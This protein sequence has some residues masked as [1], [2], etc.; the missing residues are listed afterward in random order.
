MFKLLWPQYS[1]LK[2]SV[3]DTGKLLMH[4][5]VRAVFWNDLWGAFK[6]EVNQKKIYMGEHCYT[7]TINVKSSKKMVIVSNN[8]SIRGPE[9]VTVTYF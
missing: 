9:R 1:W 5:R 8:L 2:S 4:Q 3:I 7:I 6:E